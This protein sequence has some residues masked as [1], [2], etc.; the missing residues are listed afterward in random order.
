[1]SGFEWLFGGAGAGGASGT[2][3]AGA[4]TS[5]LATAA[6]IAAAAA[7]AA[8]TLSQTQQARAS[9]DQDRQN[10]EAIIQ[11]ARYDEEQER[12]RGRAVVAK[13]KAQFA[14]G[15]FDVDSG[16]PL[17]LM[18][19]SAFNAELNALNVKKQAA[20]DAQFY[21]TRARRTRAQVPG[22]IFEGVAKTGAQGFGA[23]SKKP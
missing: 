20:F 21:K 8:S 14:A 2:A 19:D 4:S 18:M 1:M 15:G 10:A 22:L 13:Q 17:E 6:Q 7:T 16:T 5:G 9:A 12:R 23:F 11:G 3:A